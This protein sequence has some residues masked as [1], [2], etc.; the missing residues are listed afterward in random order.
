MSF[1][2][3]IVDLTLTQ[4]SWFAVLA[5]IALFVFLGWAR[6]PTILSYFLGVVIS[7]AYIVALTRGIAYAGYS[8]AELIFFKLIAALSYAVV[9]ATVYWIARNKLRA[10][11]PTKSLKKSH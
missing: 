8:T 1:L 5:A 9:L 2:D 6:I 4:L 7:F 3:S 10:I 11:K